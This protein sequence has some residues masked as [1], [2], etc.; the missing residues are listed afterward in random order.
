MFITLYTD[1]SFSPSR[2]RAR[3]AW[4]G[5]CHAGVIE[6]AVEIDSHDINHAEMSAIKHAI[7]AAIERY[8]DLDGFFV[9]ADN[10]S[11]VKAFWTFSKNKCP[12]PA[13]EVFS[14]INTLIGDRWIRAKHVKAHTGR[15]DIRSYM[16]RSVDTMTRK[17]V[18]RR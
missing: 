3:I 8:P 16:N 6:G 11:C 9:N 17:G 2:R 10:L 4:R 13:V 14:E 18:E 5:K 7:V 1:A 15:K 12:R